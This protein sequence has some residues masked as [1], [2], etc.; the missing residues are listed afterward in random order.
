M[1][2]DQKTIYNKR[3]YWNLLINLATSPDFAEK[4]LKFEGFHLFV[5]YLQTSLDEAVFKFI[6]N[7]FFFARDLEVKKGFSELA[8]VLVQLL[9]GLQPEQVIQISSTLNILGQIYSQKERK[10][11]TIMMRLLKL[12]NIHPKIMISAF[13]FLSKSIGN[14]IASEGL[15]SQ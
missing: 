12:K 5:K 1:L 7:C 15:V 4:F 14:Q 9:E 8:I 13:N 10:P 2:K 3:T 11:I 6:D